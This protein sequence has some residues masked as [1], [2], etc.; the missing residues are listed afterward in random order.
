MV[1]L[2]AAALIAASA[3]VAQGLMGV[4][5]TGLG[6]KSAKKNIANLL[7]NQPIY[8][9]PEQYYQQLNY[10]QGKANQ[11]NPLWAS[12]QKENI[13][14]AFAGATGDLKESAIS[15]NT[16][17]AGIGDLFSK[18]IQAYQDLGMQTQQWQEKQQENYMNTLQQ[19]ANYADTAWEQNK[20]RPWEIQIN[21]NESKLN[22]GWQN[23]SGG[24][25]GIGSAATNFMGTK[26]AQSVMK[27]LQ[28]TGGG[29][30]TNPI[31]P[32]S[33]QYDWLFDTQN[34]LRKNG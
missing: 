19:G 18:R 9:T 16:L 5:Q 6:K 14:Q 31:T 1:P 21:Q 7:A 22:A 10:A 33:G 23:I 24:L 3:S 8:K 29:S 15:S 4:A 28:N 30:S 34:S 17:N 2:V 12:Q 25:Q 13:G 27:G 20:L 11:G 32:T 26:Y